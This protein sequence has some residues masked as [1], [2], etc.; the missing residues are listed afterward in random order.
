[1]I[2]LTEL[3]IASTTNPL[4]VTKVPLARVVIGPPDI[5]DRRY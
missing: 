5:A 3:T 1:M 2:D 4:P